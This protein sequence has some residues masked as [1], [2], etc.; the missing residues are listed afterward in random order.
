[1][2]RSLKILLIVLAA[3]SLLYAVYWF[4]AAY[5]IE[6]QIKTEIAKQQRADR[7]LTLGK[8]DVSGFPLR[9]NVYLHEIE[10]S[11]QGDGLTFVSDGPLKIKVPSYAP[12]N[13]EVKTGGEHNLFMDGP[14][15]EQTF[16]IEGA[17][18]FHGQIGFDQRVKEFFLDASDLRVHNE[19]IGMTRIGQLE[20]ALFPEETVT[21]SRFELRAGPLSLPATL[22]PGLGS[23]VE[24]LSVDGIVTPFIPKNLNR[25]HLKVWA[26]EEGSV[27]LEAFKMTWGE[28][29]LSANGKIFFDDK[30][31]PVAA[32]DLSV[33]GHK[34]AL[35]L[36]ADRGL[37]PPTKAAVLKF[38]LAA[39]TKP[40][41]D[42]S[43]QRFLFIPLS[44]KDLL[45]K[46]GPLTLKLPSKIAN[47]LRGLQ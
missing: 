5:V 12:W 25:G 40:K 17:I 34:Q 16:R 6:R 2:P 30:M 26:A 39:F 31:L 41:E 33:D 29:D 1:M 19:E 47:K 28:I 43:G 27:L 11:D 36:F 10:F 22:N 4:A 38:S 9:F 32:M 20:L 8:I 18:K 23:V 24:A 3:F 7:S 46:V 14:S 35:K 21:G 13:F 42:G 45:L 37:I 15:G 44:L